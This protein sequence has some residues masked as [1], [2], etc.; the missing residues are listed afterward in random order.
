MSYFKAIE[1]NVK[2]SSGNSSTV[3]LTSSGIFTG[4]SDSTLG[5]NAIQVSLYT[6]QKCIVYVE[7]S[8]NGTNWD[9]CD[10]YDYNEN[11][12]FGITVQ[13][14]N[15]YVRVR[16]TN[17]NSSAAT[18]FFRL[19]TALCPIVE[20]LPRSLDDHGNLKVS[21]NSIKDEYGFEA[22]CSPMNQLRV[23]QVYKLIG[24]VG[25]GSQVDPNFWSATLAN[26]GT[27]VES[28][29]EVRIRTNTTLNGSAIINSNRNARYVV[30]AAN[31]FIGVG[32]TDSGISGNVRRWGVFSST[33]GAFYEI[34]GTSFRCVTR[35]NSTDIIT[36]SGYF[37]GDLG[38]SYSI[39]TSIHTYEIYYT[40]TQVWFSVDGNLLHTTSASTTPWT[41]NIH[42]PIRAEN[43]NTGITTD[44]SL[45]IRGAKLI[46]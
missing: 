38:S 20:A 30:G 34:N 12:N 19:Q 27:V 16:V 5:V 24:G 18:S 33:N 2:I 7:Q 43:T 9:I 39:G 8:P 31:Y 26:G 28:S 22:E 1:Q 13:A 40:T 10:E 14:V 25:S 41:T 45:Y 4:V 44:I 35:N 3:N 21:I 46:D 29:G 37:N 23:T 15:S 17:T 11:E 32:H 36:S 6:D 42:L